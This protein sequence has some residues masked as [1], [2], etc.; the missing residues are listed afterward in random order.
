[1]GLFGALD[2][3][4]VKECPE[5]GT[6]PVT[7]TN[8]RTYKSANENTFIILEFQLDHPQFPKYKA[9]KW[10]RVYPDLLDPS[11]LDDE[12]MGQVFRNVNAYKDWMRSLGV[13]EEELESADLGDYTGLEGMAYGYEADKYNDSGKEWKIHQFKRD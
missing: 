8:Y 11:D 2:I 3:A 7:F 6:H 5:K 12:E 1:M 9:E 10:L 13:P 4:D